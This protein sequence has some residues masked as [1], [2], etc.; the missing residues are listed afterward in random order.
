M[1]DLVRY[2]GAGGRTSP[3]P[4]GVYFPRPSNR[5]NRGRCSVLGKNRLLV[6]R[7]HSLESLVKTLKV[8]AL[9]IGLAASAGLAVS[10][11]RAPNDVWL[12]W[13]M[14]IPLMLAIRT[15]SPIYAAC[16][17]LFWGVCLFVIIS[18]TNGAALGFWALPLVAMVPA[19]YAWLASRTTRRA[20]FCP[21]LLAI[22]WIGVEIAFGPLGLQN[23]LLAGAQEHAL[24]G[25]TLGYLFGYVAV[26]FVVVYVNASILS[27]LAASTVVPGGSR[28]APRSSRV[29]PKRSLPDPFDVVIRFLQPAQ[30]RGP[31]TGLVLSRTMSI[32]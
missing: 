4:P 7:R 14:L 27:M 21:L 20:G 13:I 24:V 18:V 28:S 6:H 23:G 1:N 22:G 31:P 11:S 19:A 15:L 12:A 8:L 26:A 10:T 25:R 3:A 2:C 16:A 5:A 9:A 32:Q 17:G 29:R 30:A